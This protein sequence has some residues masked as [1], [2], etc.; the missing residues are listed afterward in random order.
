MSDVNYRPCALIPVY[1]HHLKIA[2][3]VEQLIAHGLDCLLIDDGSEPICAQ[4]LQRLAQQYPQ[5]TLERLAEN[6]G[7]GFA[8]CFGLK[9]AVSLGYTHALQVDADGQHDLNDIP[10]FIRRGAANPDAVISG[11]RSYSAMPPSRRRGR[12]LT[13]FW[14]CVN[15]LSREIK[16]SMCGYRLYP[17]EQTLQLLASEKIGA[18]MDF[19]TDIIVRL[20]WRGVAV[21]NIP[22]SIVYQ[23]DII[24]H[25][26]IFMDNVRITWMHTRLFGGMLLRIPKLVGRW[27]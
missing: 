2:A 3:V 26:D 15:T 27:N 12:R 19:D 24:S 23:D 14:V 17:L 9:K 21:D 10:E 6:S 1:N 5:V 18:R 25:F 16:D 20:Y 11:W 13:D 22:T 4:T 7:K 8:V